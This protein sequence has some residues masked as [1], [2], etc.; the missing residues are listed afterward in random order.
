M[1]FEH[2][3]LPVYGVQFH[4]E[5]ILTEGGY[6]LLANFLRAAGV[7]TRQ[8]AERLAAD[9]LCQPTFECTPLPESPVTF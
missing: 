2:A 6:T 5:A 1:A 3:H 8:Q 7:E 4:P 9:E